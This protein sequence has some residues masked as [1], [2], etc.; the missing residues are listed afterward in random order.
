VHVDLNRT[1]ATE[2]ARVNF[3]TRLRDIVQAPDGSVLMV[4]DG[5]EGRL[6]RLTPAS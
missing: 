1:S 6:L 5:P 3:G 2:T 4:E